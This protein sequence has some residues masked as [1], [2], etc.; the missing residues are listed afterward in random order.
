MQPW[1]PSSLP[2]LQR[3]FFFS[4]SFCRLFFPPFSTLA[5]VQAVLSIFQ[6]KECRSPSFSFFLPLPLPFL[7]SSGEQTLQV[8]VAPDRPSFPSKSFYAGAFRML[9]D[10]HGRNVGQ[11]GSMGLQYNPCGIG[12]KSLMTHAHINLVGLHG[13]RMDISPQQDCVHI[14]YHVH[15]HSTAA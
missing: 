12:D 14:Y 1:N 3:V 15:C 6:G 2:L 10:R 4:S 13:G 9:R 5:C 11:N 8:R 7:S